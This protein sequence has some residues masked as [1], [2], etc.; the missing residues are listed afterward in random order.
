NLRCKRRGER[1]LLLLPL[2]LDAKGVGGRS[3]Q[4]VPRRAF[5][6]A[7]HFQARGLS[8]YLLPARDLWQLSAGLVAARF[9]LP[10]GYFP[11][12]FALGSARVDVVRGE[13]ASVVSLG[14]RATAEVT[15]E[16]L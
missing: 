16:L 9:L 2:A 14:A 6:Q 11:L 10:S 8:R 3:K 4:E 1:S 7:R 12:T 5:E 13:R 15:R